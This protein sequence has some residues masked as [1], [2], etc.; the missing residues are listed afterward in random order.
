MRVTAPNVGVRAAP[1]IDVPEVEPV[2]STYPDC[3]DT[4][5]TVDSVPG[6]TPVTVTSPVVSSTVGV[7]I[8]FVADADHSKASLKL[9]IVTV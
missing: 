9:V 3:V 7:A 1:V 2:P 8:V 5:V 6:A 4:T